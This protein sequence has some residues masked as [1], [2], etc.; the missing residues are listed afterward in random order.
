MLLVL[1]MFTAGMPMRGT[2][3]TSLKVS[4]SWNSL[5]NFFILN[6]NIVILAEYNKTQAVTERP[7]VVA[8]FLPLAVSQLYIAYVADALP[9]AELLT[10]DADMRVG[11]VCS[12][13]V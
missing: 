2:E 13:L 9:F 5:R 12:P 11:E 4:N 8:R 10:V 3:I 6:N 1:V 7:L